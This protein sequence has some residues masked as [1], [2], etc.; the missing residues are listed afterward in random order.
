MVTG[1]A[2]AGEAEVAPETTQ[3]AAVIE[4]AA[5]VPTDT[6]VRDTPP[7][8][9]KHVVNDITSTVTNRGI[10]WNP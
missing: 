2:V 6:K 4:V 10:A 9:L 1:E 3:A 7:H 8:L 5:E